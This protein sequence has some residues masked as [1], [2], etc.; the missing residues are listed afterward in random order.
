MAIE[1]YRQL[2]QKIQDE[3]DNVA[4]SVKQATQTAE[5]QVQQ[6]NETFTKLSTPDQAAHS[7]QLMQAPPPSQ[8]AVNPPA[9]LTAD[10][11]DH[12]SA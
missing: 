3:A 7:D 10:K 2:K 6:I 8:P 9:T 12:K 4:Q 11:S 5:L 1:E